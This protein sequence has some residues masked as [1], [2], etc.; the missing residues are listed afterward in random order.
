MPLPPQTLID[1]PEN[2][3]SEIV[4]SFRREGAT[5]ITQQKMRSGTWIVTAE[6]AV[7]PSYAGMREY[8]RDPLRQTETII[9]SSGKVP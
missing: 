8:M 1:I 6:F 3:V 5:N 4:E 2:R 9:S 7:P